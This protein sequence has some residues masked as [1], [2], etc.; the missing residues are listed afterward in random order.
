[1]S[2]KNVKYILIA[3]F[4]VLI[5]WFIKDAFTQPGVQDLKGEFTEVAFYRNENNT[6]PI[7]RIYAVTVS[8]SLWD[9]MQQY[10]DFMPHT[11]Y[12]TTKVYFFLQ[13]Q[14][15]PTAVAPGEQNFDA[16]F[17]PHCLA[18]YEKDAMGQVS[19]VKWPFR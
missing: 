8:D 14:P 6:G 10:G 5:I 1:M 12:G 17:Q 13:G 11:K 7:Q 2:G 3:V 9:Q 15:A 16:Q 19:L 4:A 18:R